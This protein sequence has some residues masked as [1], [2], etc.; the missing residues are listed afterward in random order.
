MAEPVILLETLLGRVVRCRWVRRRAF[1]G[2]DMSVWLRWL[3]L[4]V[5]VN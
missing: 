3:G 4:G 2:A 5:V 1:V